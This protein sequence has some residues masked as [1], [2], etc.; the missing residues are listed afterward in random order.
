MKSYSSIELI[1]ILNNDGWYFYKATG[2]HHN[3]EH[4]IK[5][6]KV[7]IPHPRKDIPYKTAKSIIKQAEI[8]SIDKN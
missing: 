5:K 7:T 3:F 6:G 8:P 2:S 1:K 4:P